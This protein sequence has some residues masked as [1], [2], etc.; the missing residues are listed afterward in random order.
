LTIRSSESD[1]PS[2]SHLLRAIQSRPASFLSNRP[3]SRRYGVG[4]SLEPDLDQ[5]AGLRRQG[6]PL[7]AARWARFHLAPLGTTQADL[8][9]ACEI[10]SIS[11]LEGSQRCSLSYFWCRSLGARL[12]IFE[13]LERSNLS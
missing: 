6:S 12:T 10:R 2:E 9:S 1:G 13:D 3:D 8:K 11:R 4:I 7:A 5:P